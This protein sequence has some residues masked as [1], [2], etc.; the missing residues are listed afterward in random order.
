[1]VDGLTLMALGVAFLVGVVVGSGLE[2]LTRD[3]QY[4]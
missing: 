3:K 1:M 2:I 4:R